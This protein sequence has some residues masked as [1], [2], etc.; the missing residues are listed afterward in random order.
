LELLLSSPYVNEKYSKHRLA[1]M[2]VDDKKN[3]YQLLYVEIRR[4]QWNG[5]MSNHFESAY[6]YL[7][8]KLFENKN[9]KFLDPSFWTNYIMEPDS[10]DTVT[11]RAWAAKLQKVLHPCLSE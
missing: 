6:F 2:F 3:D 5:W 1:A 9:V 8:R 7:L 10:S 4:Y 11:Q